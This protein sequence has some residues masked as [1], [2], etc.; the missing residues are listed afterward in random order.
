MTPDLPLVSIVT[1]SLNQGRFI[2]ATLQSVAA[3]SYP[4]IEHIIMDGGS[5]DDSLTI[6]RAYAEAYPD[7]VSWTSEPDHGQTDAI[8][9]GMRRTSGSILAYLNSDDTYEPDAIAAVVRFF[10]EHPDIALVHGRGFHIDTASHRLDEYPAKPCDHSSLAENCHICQPTAF[11]R[12]EVLNV[13]GLFDDSL[14]YCMDY[15]YWIRTSRLYPIAY[16]DRHLANT[17]LHDAAKTVSQRFPAHRETVRMIRKH[18]GAVSDHWIYSYAHSFPWVNR[19][20]TGSLASALVYV[21][22]FTL[23]AGGLFL[24]YNHRIPIRTIKQFFL[25]LPHFREAASLSRPNPFPINH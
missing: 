18:Y 21:P 7:R 14:H 20:R 1:P 24:A 15:D 16:L 5:T 25:S 22:A 11:W 19:L 3:Q 2:A 6:I 10:R 4:H 17:R 13:I 8:N 23:L 12:R 9:R